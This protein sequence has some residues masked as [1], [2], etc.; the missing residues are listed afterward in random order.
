MPQLVVN[1]KDNTQNKDCRNL[2]N[3]CFKLRHA[4]YSNCYLL[5]KKNEKRNIIL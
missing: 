4:P 2:K 1:M 3:N 5:L